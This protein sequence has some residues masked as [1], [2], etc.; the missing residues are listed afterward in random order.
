MC[1]QS[2]AMETS[3]RRFVT[4]EGIRGTA[5]L[6]VVMVHT[7]SFFRPFNP[8][9]SGILAVDVFFLLSGFVIA[10]AYGA[11]LETGLSA[12]KFMRIRLT[13]FYPIHLLALGIAG[14][15]SFAAIIVARHP[16]MSVDQTAIWLAFGILFLPNITGTMFPLNAVVW[17]LFVEL[18]VNAVFASFRRFL[19][20]LTL[21][22]IIA[23]S[24]AAV[25][26]YAVFDQGF[27][28]PGMAS[29]L[30]GGFARGSFSFF[31]GVLLYRQREN[32]PAIFKR[33]SPLALIAILGALMAFNPAPEW[34]AVYCLAV[35]FIASPFLI[36]VGAVTE[37][38]GR[39]RRAFSFLGQISLALYLLHVPLLRGFSMLAM[40]LNWPR[41]LM[42]ILAIFLCVGAATV[43]HIVDRRV[44]AAIVRR[45]AK[46]L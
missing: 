26:A 31:A 5:A 36:A 35:V 6:A 20:N 9:P 42:G 39:V 34:K 17:S 38:T 25:I 12:M 18:V 41:V 45:T 29:N 16:P 33:V 4:L 24:G 15:L 44:Q 11:R 37:P 30:W 28:Q 7:Q 22:A 13:R 10:D 46:P 14:F 32:I 27:R 3:R 1:V 23:V 2:P 19:S 8:A 43:A 40:W 21:M